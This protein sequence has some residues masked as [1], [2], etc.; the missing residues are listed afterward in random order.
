MQTTWWKSGEINAICDV[1]GFKFKM[2]ELRQRW[3][4]LLTCL[5]DWE[6]RHPQEKIHPIPDQQKLPWTRPEGTDVFVD[7]TYAEIP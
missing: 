6:T 2:S 1:C 3:D 4:G 7:V 5:D